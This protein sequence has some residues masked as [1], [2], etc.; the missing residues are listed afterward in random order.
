MRKLIV[1]LGIVF[2]F[3]V[4]SV[5]ADFGEITLDRVTDS[6]GNKDIAVATTSTIYS[7]SFLKRKA[8]NMTVMYKATS[9]GQVNLG[10]WLLQSY[11]TPTS[12]GTVD[13]LYVT[14]DTL[15]VSLLDKDWHIATIDTLTAMPYGLFKI[16]G[17][18]TN[19]ATTTLEIVTG[20]Q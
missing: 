3:N 11:T 18:A 13:T 19:A 20:K 9:L 6:N 2:L 7:H 1:L 15:K 17:N 10:I 8:E 14:T 12:E 4:S 16:K 5:F